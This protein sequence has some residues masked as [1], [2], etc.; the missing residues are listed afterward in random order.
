MSATF[1]ILFVYTGEMFPTVIRASSFAVCSL[2][3]RF[4]S[5]IAP[6]IS[7]LTYLIPGLHGAVFTILTFIGAYIW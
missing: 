7:K 4:G 1:A 6:Q 3:G 2:G 5:L